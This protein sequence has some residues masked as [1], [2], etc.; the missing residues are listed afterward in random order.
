[1]CRR[2]VLPALAVALLAPGCAS[3]AV[4]YQRG[5][6]KYD[7]PTVVSTRGDGSHPIVLAR[8]YA[9]TLSPDGRLVAYFKGQGAETL[10][11]RP[12]RGGAARR[13]VHGTVAVGGRTAWSPDSR[14]LAVANVQGGSY[15]VDL[16]SGTTRELTDSGYFV[17]ASFSPGGRRVAIENDLECDECY[18]DIFAVSVDSL[19]KRQLGSGWGPVWGPGG[20][21]FARFNRVLVRRHVG[22]P[23]RAVF[24]S[25][26]GAS[27][28]DWSSDGKRLLVREGV[29]EGRR[30]SRALVLRPGRAR[31][32]EVPYRFHRV[33]DL[34]K[35]G[36]EVLG[37]SLDGEIVR[38]TLDGEERAL[39]PRGR[40]PS[41]S[42]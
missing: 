32:I 20:L 23:A 17:A 13:L 41:W 10:Y 14:T 8:G 40:H 1:M 21:A 42:D 37:V 7:H 27:A 3:A 30:E 6:S 5:T 33:E 16:A 38:V 19:E 31:P 15:L 39:A 34:S 12:V 29:S 22:D 4:V 28:V 26:R 2:A 25:R 18:D 24:H 9:P 11:V 36:K 35:D